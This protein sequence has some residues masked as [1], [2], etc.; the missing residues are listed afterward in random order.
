MWV[1]CVC[2]PC[3]YGERERP[4]V[5]YPRYPPS[6]VT[7]ATIMHSGAAERLQS[8]KRNRGGGIWSRGS[9]VLA[10]GS[11]GWNRRNKTGYSG[12]GEGVF[13]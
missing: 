12:G 7:Q 10:S 9:C 6:S 8:G 1:R 11:Q 3:G 5:R 13:S 2:V 4:D